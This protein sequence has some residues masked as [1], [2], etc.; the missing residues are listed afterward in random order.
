MESNVTKDFPDKL[1]L[2]KSDKKKPYVRIENKMK[3]VFD[4]F[5]AEYTVFKD[6]NFK[7]F[8]K[9][10]KMVLAMGQEMSIVKNVFE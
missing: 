5:M 1:F 7:N 6:L 8:E 2:I 10:T 9:T 4:K 3:K